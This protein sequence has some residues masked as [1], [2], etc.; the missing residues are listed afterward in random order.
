MLTIKQA[1][2]L[3]GGLG[4]P[5][6]MPGKAYGLPAQKCNVGSK[7]RDVDG[8]VCS[9]CYACDKG[10][11]A[12]A[13]VKAAQERRYNSLTHILW[14]D[15]MITLIEKE[16]YF[17]WHDSGDLQ[18]L[19]HLMAI[20]EIAEQCPD[21]KFWLPTKEYG[22][23]NKYNRLGGFI[24]SNLIIRVSA[25]MVDCVSIGGYEHSSTVHTGH[26]NGFVCPAPTQNGE[27]DDCRACWDKN[28]KNVSYRVH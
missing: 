2:E 18:G 17:R 1:K 20:V 6:K 27:C 24:P 16:D 13:N 14:I 12:F 15:A 21:T 4:N 28:V 3:T 8:S 22:L 7:L 5:S 23:I 19:D 25:P 26:W 10:R 11:Y 9:T